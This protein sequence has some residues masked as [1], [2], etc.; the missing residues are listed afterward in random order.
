[1][2]VT[3]SGTE[4][5]DCSDLDKPP[6]EEPSASDRTAE[7]ASRKLTLLEYIGL[8]TLFFAAVGPIPVLLAIGQPKVS[9]LEARGNVTQTVNVNLQPPA[10]STLPTVAVLPQ[11]QIAPAE[12]GIGKSGTGNAAPNP[13]ASKSAGDLRAQADVIQRKV[14]DQIAAREA[15]ARQLESDIQAARES[16]TIPNDPNVERLEAALAEVNGDIAQ[17]RDQFERAKQQ[18]RTAR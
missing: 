14:A 1:M 7:A 13:I 5:A 17:L 6:P 11:P 9:P 18:L 2:A 15:R 4:W 3:M 16:E 8:V 12:A 10:P